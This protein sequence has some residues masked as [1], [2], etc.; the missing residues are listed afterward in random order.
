MQGLLLLLAA[1]VAAALLWRRFTHR[2]VGGGSGSS[3]DKL[4]ATIILGGTA[5]NPTVRVCPDPLDAKW[6]QQVRWTI[7]DAANTGAEVWLTGFKPKGTSGKKDPL[8]GP[9]EKRKNKGSGEIRDKVKRRAE[10]GL[11]DYEIWLNGQMAA[12]PDIFIREAP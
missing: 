3:R 10:K 8:E 11:Y 2:P 1:I 9:D 5:S 7:D 6:G 12:D 4:D